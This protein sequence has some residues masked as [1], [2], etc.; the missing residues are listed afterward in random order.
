MRGKTFYILGAI[1]LLLVGYGIFTFNRLVSREETVNK[2][3]SEIQ[4]AYQRRVDLIPNLVNI[5]QGAADYE[6]ETI[7]QVTEAR[8][9][10]EQG[11]ATGAGIPTDAAIL[12]FMQAQNGLAGITNKLL[13]QVERYP[14]LRGA[15]AFAGLQV[16]L[17]GTERRIKFARKDFNEAVQGYNQLVRGFPSSLFARLFGFPVRSGFQADAGTDKVVEINF[18]P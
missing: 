13:L 1:I 5:V 10:A 8:N 12:Q 2:Q 17:E 7:V 14:E 4:N 18:K 11:L 6:R 16:Q 9:R 15:E 3:W